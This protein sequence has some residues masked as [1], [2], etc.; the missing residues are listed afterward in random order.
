MQ[1]I[2]SI[3]TYIHLHIPRVFCKCREDYA[4]VAVRDNRKSTVSQIQSRSQSQ[5]KLR[6]RIQIQIQLVESR[7]PRSTN[8]FP[9][10]PLCVDF[11][12]EQI[13]DSYQIQLRSLSLSLPLSRSA[14]SSSVHNWSAMMMMVCLGLV[15]AQ[16]VWVGDCFPSLLPAF[17]PACLPVVSAVIIVNMSNDLDA[18]ATN[19]E[20]LGPMMSRGGL[21]W[22]S[23]F[24]AIALELHLNSESN[25]IVSNRTDRTGCI[26][27]GS[28]KIC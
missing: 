26:A 23:G 11:C 14:T 12:D 13:Y 2:Y 27:L 5:S 15:Q 20:E 7:I 8:A 4:S 21:N 24:S 22:F 19:D 28:V 1:V 18:D 3:M 16:I 6:I 10:A 9:N 17:L 25:R